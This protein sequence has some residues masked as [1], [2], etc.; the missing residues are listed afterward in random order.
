[1]VPKMLPLGCVVKR[2]QRISAEVAFAE[3]NVFHVKPSAL[4]MIRAMPVWFSGQFP[5]IN[6]LLKYAPEAKGMYPSVGGGV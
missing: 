6:V 1:M 4:V 5:K 2:F 3:Y